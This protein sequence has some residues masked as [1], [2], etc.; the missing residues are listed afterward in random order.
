MNTALIPNI[1]VGG[2]EWKLV[3]LKQDIRET[4]D[5]SK[6]HLGILQKMVS[7]YDK[8]AQDTG[9]I[10]PPYSEQQRN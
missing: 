7:S 3:N 2:G 1:S 4:S 9:I 5:L 6:D 10:K 8:W